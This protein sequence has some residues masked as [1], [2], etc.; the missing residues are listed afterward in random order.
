MAWHDV[1]NVI[2]TAGKASALSNNQ[3]GVKQCKRIQVIRRR[4]IN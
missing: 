1:C 3:Q 4:S 2:L